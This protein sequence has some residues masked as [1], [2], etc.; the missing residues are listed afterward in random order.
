MYRPGERREVVEMSH[1]A[2]VF[3]RGDA[4]AAMSGDQ[5]MA[6]GFAGVDAPGVDAANDLVGRT[7]ATVSIGYVNVL[8]F[9]AW[10]TSAMERQQIDWVSRENITLVCI[11]PKSPCLGTSELTYHEITQFYLPPNRGDFLP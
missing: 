4:V 10:D 2:V 9:R 6:A 5:T 8:A 1:G 7:R 11:C 3:A